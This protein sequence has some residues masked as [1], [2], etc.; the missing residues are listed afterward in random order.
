MGETVLN[1]GAPQK[2]KDFHATDV[3]HRLFPRGTRRTA[4]ELLLGD[5]PVSKLVADYNSPLYV[6]DE[7]ELRKTLHELADTFKTLGKKHGIQTV[8]FYAAKAGLTGRTA[9]IVCETPFGLDVASHGELALALAAGFPASRLELHG[10]NKSDAELELA[11][12][13]EVHTIIIDSEDEI[14]RV[15]AYV[16]AKNTRQR[17]GAA[18][19]AS[20]HVATAYVQAVSLRVNSGVHASTHDFLAT[21]HEDQKFGQPREKALE[22]VQRIAACKEL[23][24]RG[25]HCHIGSQIF[26]GQ[27]FTESAKRLLALYPALREIL[28]F[29]PPELNLGGG[30]GVPYTPA[31]AARESASPGQFV[32]RVLAAVAQCCEEL[33]VSVPRVSF[34]PGRAVIA[35]AGVILYTVGSVKSVQLQSPENGFV[36]RLYVSVDG[37]MSD[38]IRPALYGADYFALLASRVSTAPPVLARVVGSHCESGDVVVNSVLLPADVRRGDVLAVPVAG[39]YCFALSSNYNYLPRPAVV[40]VAAPGCRVHVPGQSIAE[41]VARNCGVDS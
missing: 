18:T 30:F 34:E 38:N 4:G 21:S 2:N 25:L 12:N 14:D 20:E 17:S 37:G 5:V 8:G 13:R 32:D 1:D 23:S 40:G 9:K 24:F 7:D 15:A 39:A 41:L 16:R 36:E 31:E 33:G 6:I 28:G 19:F 26:D 27:G 22:L 3:P 10:N 35:R 29:Y 11:V